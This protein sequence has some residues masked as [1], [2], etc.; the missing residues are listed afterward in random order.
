P[1]PHAAPPAGDNPIRDE[2]IALQ[3]AYDVLNRAVVL[4]DATGVAE[5]FHAVHLRKQATAA[6]I[7]AGTARPPKNADRVD[8]FVA[9]DEAFHGLLETTVDAAGRNDLATLR[10][11]TGELRDECIGCHEEFRGG[12]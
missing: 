2:M 3:A 8:D 6:G 5:A 11:M 9:R 10:R 7:A 1:A 4:G 12:R